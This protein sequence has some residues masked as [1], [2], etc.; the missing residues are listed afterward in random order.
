MGNS[1]APMEDSYEDYQPSVSYI[2]DQIEPKDFNDEIGDDNADDCL[3]Y[4]EE[5][6]G[7]NDEDQQQYENLPEITIPKKKS[8]INKK[9]ELYFQ[10]DGLSEKQIDLYYDFVRVA[11]KAWT[12]RGYED[13]KV[14]KQ[15]LNKISLLRF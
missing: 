5:F 6:E 4:A 15:V 13:D 8:K 9:V 10:W 7:L 12:E 14:E 3:Y 1:Q 2:P 11:K